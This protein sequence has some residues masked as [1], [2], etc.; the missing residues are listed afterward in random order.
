MITT[1]RYGNTSTYLVRGESAAILCDTDYAG[2]LGAFFREIKAQGVGLEDISYVMATHY[3]PD[4]SGII[5]ELM[6]LGVKLLLID[7]QMEY[8]HFPDAIFARDGRIRYEP[9]DEGAAVVISCAQSR[10]FLASLGIGGE[11]ISVPSHSADSVALILDGDHPDGEVT[12]GGSD[13]AGCGKCAVGGC[14]IAGDLEP[15]EYIDAYDENS[16]LRADWERVL[17][18]RPQTVYYA[19]ANAKHFG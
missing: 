1:L 14:C 18:H 16:A 11:I 7:V 13:T 9:V 4:H 8:V 19:H 17:S 10:A 12:A 6:R 2:T 15:F 3:H 5:G